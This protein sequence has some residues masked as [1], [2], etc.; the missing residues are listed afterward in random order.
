MVMSSGRRLCDFVTRFSQDVVYMR[1]IDG[2]IGNY[3]IFVD[4]VILKVCYR[5]VQGVLGGFQ[6]ICWILRCYQ[7]RGSCFQGV[8]W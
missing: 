3:R 8:V 7:C 4:I 6:V 2:F 5:I 1:K